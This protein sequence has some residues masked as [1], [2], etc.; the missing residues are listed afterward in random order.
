MVIFLVEIFDPEPFKN[1]WRWIHVRTIGHETVHLFGQSR[2]I[3]QIELTQNQSKGCEVIVIRF[4]ELTCGIERSHRG[5]VVLRFKRCLADVILRLSR[6]GTLGKFSQELAKRV[7]HVFRI[8]L[9]PENQRL[10]LQR[11]LPFMRAGIFCDNEI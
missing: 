3:F 4:V 5:F 11:G 10:Q 1:F 2:P 7:D 9:L 8:F 6:N